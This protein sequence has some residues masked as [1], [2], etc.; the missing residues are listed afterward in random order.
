MND[1][2]GE[3]FFRDIHGNFHKLTTKDFNDELHELNNLDNI[4][5]S[6]NYERSVCKY[7]PFNYYK[8]LVSNLKNSVIS[9]NK[10][11]LEEG[12]Y[13]FSVFLT[14][15]SKYNQKIYFFLRN[16]KI[17]N[18]SLQINDVFDN[19]PS[20]INLNFIINITNVN[21]LLEI[22]IISEKDIDEIHSYILFNKIN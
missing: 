19:V 10:L 12:L 20:N 6:K 15:N 5:E 16:H 13:K 21:N 11:K 7:K 22:A 3:V 14:I 17:L 1:K 8:L 2:K 18:E 4:I 9:N